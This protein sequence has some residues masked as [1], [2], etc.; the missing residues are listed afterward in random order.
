MIQIENQNIT[1]VNETE[2]NILFT[3]SFVEIPS[4]SAIPVLRNVEIFVSNLTTT[5]CTLN[6]SAAFSGVV[7]VVVMRG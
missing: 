5:G 3:N 7:R 4:I 2:K 6:A 1:F